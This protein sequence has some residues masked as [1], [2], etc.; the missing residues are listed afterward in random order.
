MGYTAERLNDV[1]PIVV[2]TY[3]G[4]LTIEMFKNVIADNVRFIEEIG[5]PIYI[6]CDV[7]KLKTSFID[8]LHIMQEAAKDGDGSAN[9]DNIKM[10]VFVGSNAFA[11]MYRNTMQNR[12]TTFGMS[13]F[14]DMD[15]AI[16]AIRNQIDM[17]AQKKTS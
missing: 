2:F 5:E 10:L 6:I 4:I 11:K 14:E 15:I 3:D 16:E 1:E 12:G 9:D 8:M 13:M 17:N 7:K